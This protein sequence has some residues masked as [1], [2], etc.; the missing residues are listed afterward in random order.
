MY[1]YRCEDSLESIFTA[2]YNIYEDGHSKEEVRVVLEDE[3]YLFAET[4]PVR[5]DAAKAEKVIRTLKRRFGES[6]YRALCLALSSPD[7]EK[8]QA[9]YQTVRWGLGSDCGRNHL[10]DHLSDP[11]VNRA[12]KMARNADREYSHLRGFVRFEE[13]DGGILYAQI[14]PRN[15]VLPFLM[16]HF[17]DRFPEENFILHDVGR[18]VCGVHQDEVI[19]G[20]DEGAEKWYF[21]WGE[22]FMPKE[23]QISMD[24]VKFRA[25]FKGF[26]ESIAIDSRRNSALQRNMLPIHFRAYMTEFC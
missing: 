26:C 7:C 9:V 17:A 12:F 8:A 20:T 16:P 4:V 6:D 10:F 11:Y 22:E 21:L 14:K 25:L 1:L 15:N 2:I 23:L 13:L 18:C 5:E 19:L 24:E 3:P